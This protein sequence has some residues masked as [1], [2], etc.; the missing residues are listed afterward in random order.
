MSIV[1]LLAAI[2]PKTFFRP[3]RALYFDE[4]VEIFGMVFIL[5]GQLFR[6]SARGY[7]SEYSKDGHALIQDGPYAL[8]RNPMY[9][10]IL[11]IGLGI[12]MVLFH[13]WVAIIFLFVFMI[14]YLLLIVQEEKKLLAAFPKDYPNYQKQVPRILPSIA[15]L[16]EKNILGYLPVKLSWLKKEIG[17]ILAVLLITLF[18]ATW[19]DIKSEGARLYITEI[20]ELSVIIILFACLIS[21]LMR[22]TERLKKY[23]SNKN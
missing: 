23:V 10:G 21:Y 14:R 1:F 12:I 22:R 19:K 20:I 13:W 16:L 18:L 17:S 11:L 9:L 6:V 8:V 5:L 7:K 4:V 2:F 15:M 3:S